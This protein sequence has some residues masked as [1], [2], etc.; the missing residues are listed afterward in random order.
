MGKDTKR[1]CA[2]VRSQPPKV[3]RLDVRSDSRVRRLVG[4]LRKDF[5]FDH[6]RPTQFVSRGDFERLLEFAEQCLT[7]VPTPK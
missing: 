6:N 3:D 2:V 4:L 1:H 5:D 7:F